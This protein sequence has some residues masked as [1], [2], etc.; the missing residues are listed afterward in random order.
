MVVL[1]P[2]KAHECPASIFMIC[3]Y[4]HIN[5]RDTNGKEKKRETVVIRK[6]TIQKCTVREMMCAMSFIYIYN[7]SGGYWKHLRLIRRI[8]FSDI[9]CG[10]TCSSLR[11]KISD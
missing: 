10:V 11:K 7:L 3:I 8:R 1:N 6:C 5:T 2:I 4:V 9:L